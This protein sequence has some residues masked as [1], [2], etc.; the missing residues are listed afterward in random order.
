MGV[1]TANVQPGNIGET[2]EG[3]AA[4]IHARRDVSPQE[5][6]TARLL[7]DVEDELLKKLAEEASEIIMACKDRDY[8]HIRYEAGDLVY[9]LL[10]TL[11]RY[12]ISLNELAGELNARMK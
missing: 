10:V 12:G 4:T 1:R 5:S 8:D 2:L 9:H 3:L 11:E 6:Y 7:T